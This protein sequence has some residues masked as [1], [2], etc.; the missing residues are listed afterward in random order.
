MGLDI[1]FYKVKNYDGRNDWSEVHEFMKDQNREEVKKVYDGVIKSLSRAK[2][3]DK[4]YARVIKRLANMFS[5]PE[6]DLKPLGV[7]CDYQ[8]GKYSYTPVD[9]STLLKEEDR[10]IKY[11]YKKEDAYFRKVNFI[12]A[13]FQNKLVEEEAWVTRGDL[14]DLIDKCEKVL[15]DHSLAEE[16]LPTQSG[17]FFGSTDYD[18]WYFHDVKNC[19][20]QMKGVLKGLKDGEQLFVSMS[21]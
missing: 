13:Y 12:Y 5:F 8:T 2:D 3:Y 11:A 17:F 18:D 4:A 10:I 21:W 16:L 9:L 14:E 19:L 20:K 6:Y 1:Y 15:A 7:E